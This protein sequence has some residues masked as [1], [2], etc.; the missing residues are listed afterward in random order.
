[1]RSLVALVM[2]G[3]CGGGQSAPCFVCLDGQPLEPLPPAPALCPVC[4]PDSPCT[5]N[6]MMTTSV[7]PLVLAGGAGADGVNGTADDIPLGA[8]PCGSTG[9]DSCD[10]FQVPATGGNSGRKTFTLVFPIPSDSD[11]D[12]IDDM[13]TWFPGTKLD[14]VVELASTNGQ[15]STGVT[16]LSTD[17]QALASSPFFA[18]TG[19]T[20]YDALAFIVVTDP[21]SPV[22]VYLPTNGS[23]EITAIDPSGDVPG[24]VIRGSLSSIELD[25]GS[26]LFRDGCTTTLDSM[27]FAVEQGAALP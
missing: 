16:R 24:S 9:T 22:T 4:G 27:S 15:F 18:G 13:N 7:V 12:G 5:V 6:G 17:P 1:M 25:T 19:T 20:A 8:S 10:Y 2:L 21:R 3:A 14:L 23:L 11:G 26:H